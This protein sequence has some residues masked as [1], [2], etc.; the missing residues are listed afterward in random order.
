VAV[1]WAQDTEDIIDV[2]SYIYKQLR[3]NK[4]MMSTHA[5]HVDAYVQ[6]RKR[7]CANE[8]PFVQMLAS[9][10]GSSMSKAEAISNLFPTMDKL[11]KATEDEIANIKVGKQR[12]GHKLASNYSHILHG[13]PSP[14]SP[15][16]PISPKAVS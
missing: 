3:D 5:R 6:Q 11:V 4:L 12:I 8:N 14:I 13:P 16:S 9:V 7:K 10:D 2:I 15:V 1:H